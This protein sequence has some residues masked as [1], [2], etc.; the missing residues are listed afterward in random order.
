MSPCERRGCGGRRAKIALLSISQMMTA[1]AAAVRSPD[2]SGVRTLAD[3]TLLAFTQRG[4]TV[5]LLFMFYKRSTPFGELSVLA[6]QCSAV[7]WR[8]CG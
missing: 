3:Y 2:G 8:V 1:T 6:V 4:L 5:R 7:Q